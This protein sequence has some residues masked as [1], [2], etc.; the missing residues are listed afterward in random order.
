M[1]INDCGHSLSIGRDVVLGK[2]TYALHPSHVA[3]GAFTSARAR[4]GARSG[5]CDIHRRS[6]Y[7]IGVFYEKDLFS[8]SWNS[9]PEPLRIRS[10][11]FYCEAVKLSGEKKLKVFD[12][13]Q[14]RLKREFA[15]ILAEKAAAAHTEKALL[16]LRDARKQL[17]D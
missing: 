8:D 2:V 7:P 13:E 10:Y 9:L 3:H 14:R 17:K 4:K 1:A 6:F 15:D 12:A 16:V 5:P 11:R